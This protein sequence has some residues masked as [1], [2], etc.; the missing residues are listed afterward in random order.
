METPTIEGR[1]PGQA[2]RLH[3]LLA[4]RGVAI[5]PEAGNADGRVTLTDAMLGVAALATCFALVRSSLM[6]GFAIL[7]V[8][9]TLL[10][11]GYLVPRL[12]SVRDPI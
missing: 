9:L 7:G 12:L 5:L 10:A 2:D 3:L 1:P 8:P 4:E 6:L 11:L